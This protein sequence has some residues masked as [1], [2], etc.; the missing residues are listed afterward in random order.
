MDRKVTGAKRDRN[1]NIIALCNTGQSWSPRRKKDV[2]EDIK[3]GRTSYYVHEMP[4]R[5]YVRA[6]S[7]DTL[8][9]T[10]DATSKNSLEKLPSA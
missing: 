5:S 3:A 10:A 9:T 4:Q 8:Q 2:L 7:G 6:L 1:G